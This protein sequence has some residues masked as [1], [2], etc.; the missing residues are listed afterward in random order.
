MSKR[1]DIAFSELFAQAIMSSRVQFVVTIE[2]SEQKRYPMANG[3][4][5]LVIA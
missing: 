4:R 2:V 3:T 5:A 1:S